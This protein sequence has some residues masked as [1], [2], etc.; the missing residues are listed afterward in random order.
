MLT[1]DL[2]PLVVQR[3]QQE[4]L[5]GQPVSRMLVMLQAELSTEE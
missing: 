2:D 5:A 4:A 1:C 3:L